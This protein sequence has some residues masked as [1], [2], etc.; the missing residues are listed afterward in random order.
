MSS[1]IGDKKH[2]RMQGL[3]KHPWL[4]KFRRGLCLQWG[5]GMIS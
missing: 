4:Q 3:R 2:N 5:L 1:I